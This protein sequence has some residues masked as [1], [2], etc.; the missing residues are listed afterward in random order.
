MDI[1]CFKLYND[2][3][4]HAAGDQCLK[5]VAKIIYGSLH[6]NSDFAAR[7]GGEEFACVLPN[8]DAEGAQEIA[9]L[10]I[11][12]LQHIVL[13]HKYSNVADHVTMSIGIATSLS[14]QLLTPEAI[15]KQ[16]DAALY[17]AKKTGKNTY[18]LYSSTIPLDQ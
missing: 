4:G 10:I 5:D 15:L 1:D 12:K 14:N 17:A 2:N 3:Y 13:P 16:A 18:V 6:R 7:Y 8:T 9:T 11:E